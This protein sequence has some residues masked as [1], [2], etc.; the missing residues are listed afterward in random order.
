[1]DHWQDVY[2]H[3]EPDQVS[4]H[5]PRPEPSLALIAGTAVPLDAAILDAGGGT[6][7]LARELLRRGYTDVTVADI[8]AAA[9]RRARE[10]LGDTADRVECVEADL[11]IHRFDRAY[12]LWHD[13][14]VLHFMVDEP[15]RDRYLA[16]L[17]SAIRPG[18]HLILATF[19]PEGPTRCSGLPVRR[20]GAGELAALLTPEFSLLGSELVDHRTPGG[21]TQQFLYSHFRRGHSRDAGRP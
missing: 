17:R 16:N 13:R 7:A 20:Y 4:W 15:D 9:L 11:R 6:S 3:C 2:E 18:G 5:E 1:M 12:D 10:A 14:A 19:G 21:S 8:S